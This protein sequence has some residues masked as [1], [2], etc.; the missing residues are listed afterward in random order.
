MRQTFII[1]TFPVMLFAC[2]NADKTY[3][4]NNSQTAQQQIDTANSARNIL[5]EELKMVQQILASNNKEVI[6]TI[7]PFP[8]SG[9]EFSIYMDDSTY[10]E[11]LKANDNKT[12]KA[13]YLQYFK[14]ISASIWLDQL[15]NLFQHINVEQ[16]LHKDILEYDAYIKAE[17]CFYSYQIEVI[18]NSV[19][20]RMNMNSNKYF[21]NKNHLENDIPANSS[22]ICEHNF[23]W[24]FRFDGKK[25]HLEN[26]SG[27]G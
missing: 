9:T 1:F 14:E 2:N 19:T 18:G 5:I 17:P 12:T 22:E 6:A 26:I 20:L 7:F 8:L 10:I 11:Q 27:A 24:V 4:S 13:M 25:L 23:W 15:N 21:E 3:T 16:L